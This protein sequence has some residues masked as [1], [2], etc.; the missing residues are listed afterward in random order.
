[1]TGPV[2]KRPRC[3]RGRLSICTF[4]QERVDLELIVAEHVFVTDERRR[5]AGLPG[6][7]LQL[8]AA[9]FRTLDI[10]LLE[11]DVLARE[12]FADR[13]AMRTPCRHEYDDRHLNAVAIHGIRR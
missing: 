1:M 11:F 2:S 12:I 4:L 13:L 7:L 3:A 6:E 9:E 8:F 10:T 5:Y